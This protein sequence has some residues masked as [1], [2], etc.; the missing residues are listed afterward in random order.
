[1]ESPR[2]Q[3]RSLIALGLVVLLSWLASAFNSDTLVT[4][5]WDHAPGIGIRRIYRFSH[6]PGYT[7]YAFNINLLDTLTTDPSKTIEVS[8]PMQEN[9]G[10]MIRHHHPV[11]RT[12]WQ[13]YGEPIDLGSFIYFGIAHLIFVPMAYFFYM[14][15]QVHDVDARRF[16]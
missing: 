4:P 16:N 14:L 7:R 9:R 5:F 6:F 11:A 3:S 12:S 2:H 13:H 15:W 10:S 1:M 8:S